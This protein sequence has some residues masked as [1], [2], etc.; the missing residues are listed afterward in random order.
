MR[1]R[2]LIFS[3]LFVGLAITALATHHS[4]TGYYDTARPVSVTGTIV[5]LDWVA[6]AVFVHLRA[7]DKAT[8]KITTWAFEA[9]A[10][11]Y[12]ERTFGLSKEMFKEGSTIT[13]VGY[14]TRGS[15]DVSETVSDPELRARVRAETQAAI[16]QFEFA[17]GKKIP[18]MNTPRITR[19]QIRAIRVIRGSFFFAYDLSSESLGSAI[20]HS[21]SGIPSSLRTMFT[22]R[23][24]DT[25]L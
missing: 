10:F 20:R 1:I 8:G 22:P 4:F 19:I 2:A 16:A 13:I 9:E 23:T 14:A 24:S 6:P 18:I 12:L 11:K 15:A 17:D 25:I 3:L 5:K 21:A 7:Q